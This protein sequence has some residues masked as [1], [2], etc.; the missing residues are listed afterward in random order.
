[1]QPPLILNRHYNQSYHQTAIAKIQ[2]FIVGIAHLY[3]AVRQIGGLGLSWPDLDFI[4][5]AQ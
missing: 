2:W 5:E 4:I 3:N 1:M